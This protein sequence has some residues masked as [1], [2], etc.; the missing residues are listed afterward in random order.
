MNFSCLKLLGA[1]FST[2]GAYIDKKI[3]YDGISKNN[4]FYYMC[5]TMIP[6]ALISLLLE[7][8]TNNFI[9]NINCKVIILLFIVAFLRYIKQYSFVACYRKLEPFEL[10]TYMSL[11]LILCF[12]I[13]IILG[14]QYFTI[15]KLTSIVFIIIGVV[16]MYNVNFSI[17]NIQKDR[18]I[19]EKLNSNNIRTKIW[20]EI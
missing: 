3:I 14:I 17:K 12:F 15:L 10:K 4:Y 6:F 11:T 9:F 5:L 8:K 19:N 20:R 7:I 18:Y 13:D 1:I 16:L 2:I